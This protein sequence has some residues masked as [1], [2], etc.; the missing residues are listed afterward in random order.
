M[1]SFNSSGRYKILS[2]LGEGGMGTVYLALDTELDRK[3]AIKT[4]KLDVADKDQVLKRTMREGQI[5]SRLRHS[6]LVPVYEMDMKASPP[7]IIQGYVEGFSLGSRIESRRFFTEKEAWKFF[8][9]QA[10]VLSY[11]HSRKLV[12]RDIKPDNIML[13]SSGKSILM[14]FGLTLDEDRTRLTKEGSFVGTLMYL[15]FEV[16]SGKKSTAAAD[17]YQLGLVTYEAMTG[18]MIFGEVSTTESLVKTLAAGAWDNK[19]FPKEIPAELEKIIRACCKH[20]VT[21]RIPDGKT[22]LRHIRTRGKNLIDGEIIKLDRTHTSLNKVSSETKK[23]PLYSDRVETDSSGISLETTGLSYLS[24]KLLSGLRKFVVCAGIIVALVFIVALYLIDE[25]D[26]LVDS[27]TNQIV[28]N[29]IFSRARNFVLYRHGFSIFLPS[30]AGKQLSWKLD[31][32]KSRK[33]PVLSKSKI[34]YSRQGNFKRVAGGWIGQFEYFDSVLQTM[35]IR[36]DRKFV[37]SIFDNDTCIGKK[38]ITLPVTSFLEPPKAAFFF[39]RVVLK[40]KL[41]GLDEV[42]LKIKLLEEIVENSDIP[43]EETFHIKEDTLTYKYPKQWFGKQI[44]CTIVLSDGTTKVIT[45]VAGFREEY[46]AFLEGKGSNGFRQKFVFDN[47]LYLSS[48][49]GE[50][51]CL[52]LSLN[53]FRALD[54]PKESFRRLRHIYTKN[55]ASIYMDSKKLSL[56]NFASSSKKLNYYSNYYSVKLITPVTG[57]VALWGIGDGTKIVYLNDDS[58]FSVKDLAQADVLSVSVVDGSRDRLGFSTHFASSA[59]ESL[60]TCFLYNTKALLNVNL[61][62]PDELSRFV[63]YF[64]LSNTEK[65][66]IQ[67]FRQSMVVEDF[68]RNLFYF[69]GA[70]FCWYSEIS[71]NKSSDKL[72]EMSFSDDEVEFIEVGKMKSARRHLSS[73]RLVNH[74]HNRVAIDNR[75]NIA[76]ISTRSAIYALNRKNGVA[77]LSQIDYPLEKHMLIN[78]FVATGNGKFTGVVLRGNTDK[79]V[80]KYS[81]NNVC[82]LN[83][84]FSELSDKP[85][86]QEIPTGYK[87]A[88]CTEEFPVDGPFFNGEHLIFSVG[89]DFLIFKPGRKEPIYSYVFWSKYD[90]VAGN[91]SCMFSIND[92][93]RKVMVINF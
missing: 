1:M 77:T 53:S 20:D 49:D 2:T 61:A 59:S 9:E 63:S 72:F 40:W 73:S 44:G 48:N 13:D 51:H 12:H 82:L 47:K 35:K 22:L 21:E 31:S 27:K 5:L 67:F 4:M 58:T 79:R 32:C 70:F 15:P 71:G 23:I 57:G 26:S 6:S 66:S 37:L 50:L 74:S 87:S 93:D 33:V 86:V 29:D 60:L 10:E 39:D 92:S 24:R 69:D 91:N 41:H 14:D 84:S 17:I 16:L 42:E 76:I 7:Y 90:L 85:I 34:S 80:G 64:V 81:M 88:C 36:N 3:V 56:H 45:G 18:Q 38:T 46:D 11:I 68:I 65:R 89:L 28:Q 52:A 19:P 8:K 55:L 62:N 83:L 30:S 75:Q 25:Q 43:L 54:G 78:G